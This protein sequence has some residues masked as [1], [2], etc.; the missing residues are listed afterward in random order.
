MLFATLRARTEVQRSGRRGLNDGQKIAYELA[1]DR[2]ETADEFAQV[3][4]YAAGGMGISI[5]IDGSTL[6]FSA[7]QAIYPGY[8]NHAVDFQISD[9]RSSINCVL[10]FDIAEID[11]TG[12][13]YSLDDYLIGVEYMLRKTSPAQAISARSETE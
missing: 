11:V 4:A 13:Q 9:F 3:I 8:G 2:M 7:D 5:A 10:R 12:D 1:R 6:N